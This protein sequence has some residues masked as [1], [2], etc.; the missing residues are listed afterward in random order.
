MAGTKIV[1]FK[2]RRQRDIEEMVSEVRR[3]EASGQ[4]T[5]DTADLV[6]FIGTLK[7]VKNL[8]VYDA[9]GKPRHLVNVATPDEP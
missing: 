5:S 3:L 4:I 7:S 6:S 2:S 1:E 8:K 9:N